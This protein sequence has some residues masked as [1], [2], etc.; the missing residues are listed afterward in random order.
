MTFVAVYDANVLYPASMRDLLIRLGQTGLFQ[1]KWTD[2]ILDEMINAVVAAQPDLALRLYR[3]R[4]LMN[5][6][7]RDVRVVDYEH[8]IDSLRLPDPDDRHV[9]AAAIRAD[10]AFVVTANLKDFPSRR[11]EPYGIQALSPDDFVLKVIELDPALV[12]DTVKGQARALMN[13]STTLDDL[14]NR[15]GT[16]G[17]LRAANAIRRQVDE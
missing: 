2:R 13:P 8:M 14:L 10:A 17:L 11:L 5:E 3:T 7:I 12:A 1:A 4:E 16:V 15:L 6:A 9:L